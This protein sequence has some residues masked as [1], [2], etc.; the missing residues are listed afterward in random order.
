MRPR[1]RI[2]ALVTRGADAS[3]P[4]A[5]GRTPFAVAELSANSDVAD[6]LRAHGADTA[7]T[8][9]DRL[10]AACSRGDRPA[11]DVMLSAQPELKRAIAGEHYA[12]FYRAVERNDTR[13]IE[14]MLACGVDPDR[15]DEWAEA[16]RRA[17]ENRDELA[18]RGL[19]W[20]RA[21]TWQRTGR[22]VLDALA[23]AA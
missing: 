22:T 6:W 4:R 9:V 5:D 17:L 19:E 1:Q 23:E 7:I 3:R 8:D 15:P 2:E 12:A 14:A 13:A 16:I 11:V 18:A 10:V 21:F 20:A